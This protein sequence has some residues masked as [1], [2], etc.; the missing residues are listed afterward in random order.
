MTTAEI[1]LKIQSELNCRKDKYNAFGGF[2]YRNAEGIL[3]EV[4][5]LCTKHG[6]LLVLSDEL[7][8]IGGKIFI[9][10]TASI[11][12]IAPG[13]ETICSTGFA[14]HEKEPKAKM[15]EPQATGSASSFARKYALCALFLIGDSSDDPDGREN[16]KLPQ[17][18]QQN[19]IRVQGQVPP[20]PPPVKK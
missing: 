20:P 13:S 19:N 7:L 17:Q 6:A 1:L 11:T 16:I 15:C 12:G 4:K 2:S 10:N 8:E 14:M 18:Q 5:P 3:E 9:K